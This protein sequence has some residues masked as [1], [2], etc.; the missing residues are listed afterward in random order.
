LDDLRPAS[1]KGVVR[2]CHRMR[3]L[4]RANVSRRIPRN[5]RWNAVEL[6]EAMCSRQALRCAAQMPLAKDGGGIPGT[7]EKLAHREG[8][9]RKRIGEPLDGDQR[10]AATD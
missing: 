5:I 10:K 2:A 3:Q 9:G 7:L 1:D 6:I 4:H 8:A